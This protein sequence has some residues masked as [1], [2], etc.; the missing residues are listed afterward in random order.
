MMPGITYL[1]VP[2]MTRMPAGMFTFVP[3]AVIFPF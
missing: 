2:S 1:P 3:I